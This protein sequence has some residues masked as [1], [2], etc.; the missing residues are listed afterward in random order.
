MRTRA[1]WCGV[2]RRRG[3]AR[4]I[5]GLLLAL[6]VSGVFAAGFALGGRHATSEVRRM[7]SAFS[8]SE[9]LGGAAEGKPHGKVSDLAM[10]YEDPVRAARELDGWCWSVP[11]IP[12]PFVGSA[13]LPG[14]HSNA[15]IDEQQ[16]RHPSPIESPKPAGTVRV[17]VTGGST[18]FGVGAPSDADT[19]PALLQE[20]LQRELGSRTGRRYEVIN[21]ANPA[22][23]STHE[24]VLI[25]NRLSELEPDLVISFTGVNDAHFGFMGTSALWMR[26]YADLHFLRLVEW[27]YEQCGRTFPRPTHTSG[28]VPS[29]P[30][31][32]IARVL[33]KNARLAAAS[34][35]TTGA[36]YMLCL[37]PA[38]AVT[39]KALSARERSHL[40]AEILGAGAADY[41]R[42]CYALYR[43]RLPALA[44]KGVIFADANTALDGLPAE[45]EVFLDS[46]HFGDRGSRLLAR[47]LFEQ[48]APLLAGI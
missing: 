18:A 10:A 2:E 29:V 15:F 45:S 40:E 34:L 33:E 4:P 41:F 17:F 48:I 38:L 7:V 21:A 25:E 24:R 14:R 35:E 9:T 12:T 20:I 16:F 5:V 32:E 31:E 44:D 26:T 43:E 36:R 47:W 23:V 13:P 30:P 42:R 37:Q 46:Y 28:P 8:R 19:I 6:V 22:W 11:N 39:G 3:A 1:G 27:A